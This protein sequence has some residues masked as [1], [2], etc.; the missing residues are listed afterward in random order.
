MSILITVGKKDPSNEHIFL[1]DNL[2]LA[3]G[4]VWRR[5]NLGAKKRE[6]SQ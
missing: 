5:K 3:T 4:K 2:S 6:L 1:Y